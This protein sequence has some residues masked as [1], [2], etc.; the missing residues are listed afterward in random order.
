MNL[1]QTGMLEACVEAYINLRM[2]TSKP[3]GTETELDTEPLLVARKKIGI[4]VNAEKT[5][6]IFIF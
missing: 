3:G 4:E 1:K 2:E 5:K 6:D